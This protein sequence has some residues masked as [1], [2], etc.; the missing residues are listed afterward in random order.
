MPGGTGVGL[1]AKAFAKLGKG[2]VEAEYGPA[3]VELR[4]GELRLRGV[5]YR[6]WSWYEFDGVIVFRG[7]LEDFMVKN[8]NPNQDRNDDGLGA[9]AEGELM[10][11]GSRLRERREQ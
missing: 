4:Y 3:V 2:T 5:I 8:R 6:H 10:P 9:V 7:R 11:P 1:A